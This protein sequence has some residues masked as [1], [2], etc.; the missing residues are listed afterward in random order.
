[1]K[2]LLLTGFERFLQFSINPTESIVKALDGQTIADFLIEGVVL[3]VD[4]FAA[5]KAVKSALEKQNP[6][7]VLSLGLSAG[8]N[9][10]TPERI[11]IN[12]RDG[13]ADNRGVVM[14]DKRI[15]EIG[16][17]GYFS[18]LPIRKIVNSLKK[19]GFPA[20]I[21]NSAGTYLCNQVM[22]T[23]LHYLKENK[24]DIPAGFVHLPAS[25]ELAAKEK[26]PYP[27]WSQHDLQQAIQVTIAAL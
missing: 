20:G 9:A 24:R 23:V 5:S 15:S 16:A 19:H 25:H 21:S 22:Y 10:I 26:K 8:R 7:A 3:P 4:Y 13:E 18:T 27:S 6:D 1:M 11:A 14:E 12:C 17:D 2:K